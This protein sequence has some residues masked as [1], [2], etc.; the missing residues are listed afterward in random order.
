MKKIKE[1]NISLYMLIFIVS[2]VFLGLIFGSFYDLNIAK[3]IFTERNFV[4]YFTEYIGTLPSAIVFV[5]APIM[6]FI[7]FDKNNKIKFHN[8]YKYLS[9]ILVLF[10]G[11]F[12]GYDT[13]KD[14]LSKTIYAVAIGCLV[15]L[16]FAYLLYLDLK[17]K[18]SDIYL[19]IAISII[20]AFVTSIILTFGLKYLIVRPRFYYLRTIDSSYSLFRN[21]YDFSFDKSIYPNVSKSTFIQSWPSGHSSFVALLYLVLLTPFARKTNKRKHLVFVGVTIYAIFIML[22]RMLDGHHYL[23]DVATGYFIGS[24]SAFIYMIFIP[25]KFKKRVKKQKEELTNKLDKTSNS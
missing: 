17:R 1:N 11:A 6:L 10:S 5:I 14:Y 3:L 13:L 16:P 7:Y 8:V 12:W 4:S 18:Y 15:I 25:N 21:W 24:L 20:L 23:S 2:V 19:K 22:G 9:L